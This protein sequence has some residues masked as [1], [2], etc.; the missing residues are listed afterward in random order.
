MGVCGAA[1]VAEF[2]KTE[3]VIAPSIV[4]EGKYYQMTRPT[5]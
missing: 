4:T 1:D 5:I 2:H 3:M